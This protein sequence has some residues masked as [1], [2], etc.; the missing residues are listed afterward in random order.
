MDYDL[1]WLGYV[2]VVLLENGQTGGWYPGE[3]WMVLVLWAFPV[4]GR[5]L[6]EVNH[7]QIAP[8]VLWL[9]MGMIWRRV[10]RPEGGVAISLR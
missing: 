9:T 3:R 5:L 10:T 8:F 4:A 7:V 1:I 6:V 2:L